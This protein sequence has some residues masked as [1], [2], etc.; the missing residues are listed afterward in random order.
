MDIGATFQTRREI[1][2]NKQFY[3]NPDDPNV[4]TPSIIE[5]FRI[6]YFIPFLIKQFSHSQGD[7][8]N[9]MITIISLVSYLPFKTL[10]S[11]DNN[12]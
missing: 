8:N 6:R 1:K 7:L 5:S 4:A 2:R 10:H 11:M 12:N 9:M 3:E